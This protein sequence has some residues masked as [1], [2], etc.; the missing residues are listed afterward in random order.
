MSSE[1]Y[2]TIYFYYPSVIRWDDHI[3]GETV[4]QYPGRP[5][6]TQREKIIDKVDKVPEVDKS[7]CCCIL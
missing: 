6:L 2:R 7:N 4:T 3:M 1:K 5:D